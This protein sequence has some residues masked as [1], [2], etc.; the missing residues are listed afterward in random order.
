MGSVHQRLRQGWQR[1]AS[2]IGCTHRAVEYRAPVDMLRSNSDADV[3]WSLDF[4]MW[5]L[6]RRAGQAKSELRRAGLLCS[7][8]HIEV[9]LQRHQ[10]TGMAISTR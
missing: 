6:A 8:V 7:V 3:E 4:E 5:L 10:Y 2:R 1:H 9:G